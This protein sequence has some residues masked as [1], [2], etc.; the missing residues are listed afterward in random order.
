MNVRVVTA[1]GFGLLLGAGCD[2]NVFTVDV[3][4]QQQVYHADF[5]A[6]QGTIPL[7]ACDPAV[8]G[9]C[10]AAVEVAPVESNGVRAEVQLGCDGT[11]RQCYAQAH[12]V[13]ANAVDVLQDDGFI[14]KVE[15]RSVTIVRKA[16]LAYR[17]PV[18]TL[19]F[20]IPEI[21]IFVGPAGSLNPTDPGVVPVG[22]TARLPAGATLDAASEGHIIVPDG[23]SAHA[24]IET[25]IMAK[26][27]MV[28]LL[29]A[30]PRIDAGAVIPA[31]A[32]EIDLVPR[33]T[34]GL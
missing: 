29:V 3:D 18:N 2:S 21:Q 27:T 7:V 6:N 15:R 1:A 13:G 17:V 14:T 11:A 28:F 19:T 10:G 16:D 9:M 34:L 22:T 31:G 33:L 30:S 20:D 26:Q 4:L 8:A 23:S 24:L 25:S 5:G 32:L 12:L